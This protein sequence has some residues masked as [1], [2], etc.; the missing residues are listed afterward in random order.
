MSLPSTSRLGRGLGALLG[1]HLD[2]PGESEVASLSLDSVVP[3]PFQP[4]REFNE[5]EIRELAASIGAN[6]LLQPV[7]VR[8]APAPNTWELVAGERRFRAVTRLGWSELPAIVRQVD[9]ETMLVLALVE[10][11]Q[12]RDLDA[13]EEAEGYKVLLDKFDRTQ[14]EIAL[15]VGKSRAAVTNTLRLL[16]LPV[17]IRQLLREG[18]LTPG[19]ARALLAVHDEKWATELARR[20]VKGG[21][22]VRRLEDNVRASPTPP[23]RNEEAPREPRRQPRSLGALDPTLRAAAGGPARGAWDPGCRP[24][25]ERR[26]GANRDPIPQ[27]PGL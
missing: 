10:N 18:K 21:W 13:L 26:Q 16:K 8:S 19:H 1:D 5:E 2:R 9:D 15:A 23:A 17:R 7:V 6:G 24:T 14:E 3:N 25:A 11:L 4:R 12:R 27:R 20:A 22:S